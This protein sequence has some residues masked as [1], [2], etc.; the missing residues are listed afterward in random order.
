MNYV[1]EVRQAIVEEMRGLPAELIDLYTLLGVM[2][3]PLVDNED[4]HNAW[5]VWQ[6]RIKPDHKSLVRFEDLSPE[7]QDL[8]SKYRD[9]IIRA[10]TT[11]NDARRN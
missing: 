1:E 9:A 5:A 11:V 10:V 2:M 7:V 8:D 3:G 4:V 6:N